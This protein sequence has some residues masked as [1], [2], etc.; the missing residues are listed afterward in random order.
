VE[1]GPQ[2]GGPVGLVGAERGEV[3]ADAAAELERGSQ[4]VVDVGGRVSSSRTTD[5]KATDSRGA[6]DPSTQAVQTGRGVRGGRPL[7]S[8]VTL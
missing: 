6:I 7:N 2:L 1:L 3:A 4:V 5:W 8:P